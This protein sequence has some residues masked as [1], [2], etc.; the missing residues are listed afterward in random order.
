MKREKMV[1]IVKECVDEFDNKALYNDF[2]VEK[3]AR[4]IV[5]T[6]IPDGAVVLTREET[7]KEPNIM[8]DWNAG[9]IDFVEKNPQGNGERDI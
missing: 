2:D 4:K 6:L 3:C 9:R 1:D 5:L 8:Y 7:E